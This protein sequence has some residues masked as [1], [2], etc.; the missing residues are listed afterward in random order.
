MKLPMSLFFILIFQFLTSPAF[1]DKIFKPADLLKSSDRGRGGLMAGV[2][3][4]AKVSSI[5]GEK[6]STREFIVSAL[7]D[8]A[9]VE[10]VNPPRNKGEVYIF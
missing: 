4:Y 1:A 10:A 6:K 9:Y 2:K 8:D 3:W 7:G 5:E